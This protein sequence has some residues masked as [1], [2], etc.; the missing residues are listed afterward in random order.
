M[1]IANITVMF[2]LKSDIAVVNSAF[3]AIYFLELILR[4]IGIYQK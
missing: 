2:S 1:V 4:V 3:S